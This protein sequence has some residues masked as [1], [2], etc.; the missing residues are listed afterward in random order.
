MYRHSRSEKLVIMVVIKGWPDT[1]ARV[2]RSL[3]IC[4]TCFKRMTRQVGS[5]FD[6]SLT[7]DSRV[8][9]IGL[10]QNFESKD[11]VLILFPSAC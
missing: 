6:P 9:T 3:R 7:C 1:A 8:H 4:S 10:S 5:Q 2:F 11:L